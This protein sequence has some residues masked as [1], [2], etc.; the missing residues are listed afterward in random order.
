MIIT[1]KP[2][3][4][5]D[6]LLLQK[7]LQEPH[8]KEFWQEPENEQE[9]REKYVNKLK[10]RGV[11]SFI[12]EL[13]QEPIGYIQYYE[14]CRI[15]GGWWPEAQPGTFGIDQFIGVPKKV[16]KG[17][18]PKII[19]TFIDMV[20]KKEVVRE[21]I[22]DPDSKNI[23][24]IKAYLKIGF[25]NEGLISTPNGDACLMRFI[26]NQLKKLPD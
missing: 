22:A 25:T 5:E 1:F 18:G 7:W 19:F 16:G 20:C 10:N 26:P 14:A 4:E 15:G 17:L 2:F 9:L 24:A 12:I 23:R 6:I 11:A 21:I 8:V 3:Q 13:D